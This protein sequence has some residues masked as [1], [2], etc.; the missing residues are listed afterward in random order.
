MKKETIEQLKKD[1]NKAMNAP[2]VR[3]MA[4][5]SKTGAIPH[6]STLAGGDNFEYVNGAKYGV[7]SGTCG[8]VCE[9]VC[10]GACYAMCETRYP[11]VLVART[12]NTNIVKSGR[13]DLLFDGVVSYVNANNC[14]RFRWNASGEIYNENMFLCM[15]D[16]ARECPTCNFYTY[17]KRYE[18]L[19]KYADIIPDNLKMSVS[20]WHKNY[21]NPLGFHEFIYDD[22]L[23]PELAS[24]VHCPAVNKEG[25]KT[26]IT[27][28][29]CGRCARANKGEKTAVY[30]H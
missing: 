27:C 23:E 30:A 26:G 11:A 4:G 1:L 10:N 7:I 3:I 17:T 13:F 14:S 18:I 12:N 22:G 16:I 2:E 9:G 21:N 28:E 24:V 20:I 8:G 25:H 19:E 29:Q 15:V 6:F 5:N